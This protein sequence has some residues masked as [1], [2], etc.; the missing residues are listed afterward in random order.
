MALESSNVISEEKLRAILPN[1]L[2]NE[3]LRLHVQ[4]MEI[5]KK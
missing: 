1:T 2:T 4:N 3:S 5:Q